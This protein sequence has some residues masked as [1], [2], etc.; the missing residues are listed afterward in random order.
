LAAE[1]IGANDFL[2][3]GPSRNEGGPAGGAAPVPARRLACGLPAA[4]AYQLP[5][6]EANL[7]QPISLAIGEMPQIIEGDYP[8]EFFQSGA[9]NSQ[10]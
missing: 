4:W 6:H 7:G 1:E 2:L 10:R 8:D 3:L 5:L 9:E